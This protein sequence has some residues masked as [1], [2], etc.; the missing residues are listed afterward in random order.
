M[1]TPVRIAEVAGR[2]AAQ[3]PASPPIVYTGLRPGEKL[4][5][6]LFGSG[7]TDVRRIHPLISHVPA[8][9]LRPQAARALDT[10]APVKQ[11]VDALRDLCDADLDRPEPAMARQRPTS[12]PRDWT[13]RR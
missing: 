4:H 12:D 13:N 7:E 3:H 2:L 10:S 11:I 9:P 8:P 5:E 6:V 1:G